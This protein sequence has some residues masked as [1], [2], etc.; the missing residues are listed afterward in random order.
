MNWLRKPRRSEYA[1]DR[2]EPLLLRL[3]A[4]YDSNVLF[5]PSLRDVLLQLPVADLYRARWTEDIH[6]EWMAAIVRHYPDISLERL[7]RTRQLMNRAT[8]DALVVDYA[9]LIDR[10]EL[11]DPDDRHVLAAAIAGKADVIVT[12]N[13]RDFP[14]QVLAAHGIEAEHPDRFLC[15][16][17]E[18]DETTVCRAVRTIRARLK[19]PP[20]TVDDY[21]A[22]LAAAQLPEF[23]R[24]PQPHAASL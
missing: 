16:I 15:R 20:K 7:D 3:V 21:L 14:A 13:I 19:R 11:P 23:A 5:P 9:H 22:D 10:I 18:H 24:R 8:R 1:T 2:G 4:L 12:C 6:R 17:F